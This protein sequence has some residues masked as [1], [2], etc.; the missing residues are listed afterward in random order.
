MV[1]SQKKTA[2]LWSPAQGRKVQ[3]ILCA[4]RCL[5][6]PGRLG[7]CRVRLNE[8]G[9]LKS[10]NYAMLVAMNVDPVEKKPLFHFLPGSP[11]L[12][13]ACAGCNFQCE[14]CQN[15]QI[16]QIP[17]DGRIEGQFT[18]PSDVVTAAIDSGCPSISYTYTEP[19]IYF[20]TAYEYA[21]LARQKG[22]RNIF[23]SNGYMTPEAIEV[24]APFLD[25]INVDLKA[26]R[27]E[28]YRRVMKARLDPVL[29][30]LRELVARKIWVEVT[31]LV[32]PGM[33]DSTQ[34]LTDIAEFISQ[35]LGE[36]VPW[37]VTRF[38]GDYLMSNGATTPLQT[39]MDAA[40]IGLEAGLKH[41]YCGNVTGLADE[42]TYCPGCGHKVIARVGYSID[43]IDLQN[44]NCPKC[45]RPVA[46]FWKA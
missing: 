23:V 5:I 32:V 12:S 27:D 14:F 22:I 29:E 3:C 10:L 15:W 44:G 39:L 38:H 31:T 19:T 34:E 25:A 46:G 1:N 20:E 8:D 30:C 43:K 16:S 33:N 4:H 11:S 24:I 13:I 40:R 21:T 41:V 28:T 42:N 9:E 36:D 7:R 6:N 17:G 37:H 2:M 26:F 35:E 45:H 18:S